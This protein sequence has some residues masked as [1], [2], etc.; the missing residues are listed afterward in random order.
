MYFLVYYVVYLTQALGNFGFNVYLEEQ[1]SFGK[2]ICV[3]FL[4][5]LCTLVYV[6]S[7]HQNFRMESV[8]CISFSYSIGL[9][10]QKTKPAA[11]CGFSLK[12]LPRD[13]LYPE[14]GFSESVVLEEKA[15]AFESGKPW[16]DSC[17][18]QEY[19]NLMTLGQFLNIHDNKKQ[20]LFFP[21]FVSINVCEGA[22][23]K[24]D[25]E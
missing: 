20:C 6:Y 9:H 10:V 12:F 19:V 15:Q 16:F 14:F 17:L 13:W 1:D 7:A 25:A 8:N 3:Y 2:Q 24:T 4:A 22:Q 5:L 18:Y 23:Y 21:G 11:L